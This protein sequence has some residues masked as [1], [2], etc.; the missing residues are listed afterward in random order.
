MKAREFVYIG[1]PIPKV[2]ENKEFLMNVQ[3]AMLLSLEERKLLTKDETDR[4]LRH[5]AARIDRE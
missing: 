4:A 3:K 5:L 2:K 1:E